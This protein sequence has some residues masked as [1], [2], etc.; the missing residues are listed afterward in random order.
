[1]SDKK[2]Q[3]TSSNADKRAKSIM[4]ELKNLRKKLDSK[5]KSDEARFDAL[6][7]LIMDQNELIKENSKFS[8]MLSFPCKETER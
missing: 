7:K 8:K 1:M 3:K 2:I 6:E 4:S 5:E